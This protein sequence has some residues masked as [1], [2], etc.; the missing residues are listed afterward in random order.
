M[1]ER[2]ITTPVLSPVDYVAWSKGY[3]PPSEH[4]LI[5]Q[6]QFR[7]AR[8]VMSIDDGKEGAFWLVVR[9]KKMKREHFRKALE[10]LME[11]WEDPPQ[12][13]SPPTPAAEHHIGDYVANY[14][15]PTPEELAAPDAEL[16]D[17][18]RRSR[19]QQSGA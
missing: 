16:D 15:V 14:T 2:I 11:C 7:D 5:D 1:N 6:L 4:L 12:P 18:H 8:V 13:E 10:L 9:G 19:A 3:M 17:L